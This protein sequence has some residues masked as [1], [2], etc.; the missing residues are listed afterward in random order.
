MS[1]ARRRRPKGSGGVRNRGTERHPRWF[2]Y[3]T[4]SLDGRR[5]QVSGG[6]FER[7]KH[8]EAWLGGEL[9]RVRGDGLSSP[10]GR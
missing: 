2:G 7:K 6:P 3:F 4:V 1:T 9:G 10:T 5:R 8:A